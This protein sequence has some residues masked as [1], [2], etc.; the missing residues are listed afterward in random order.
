MFTL[1]Y[2]PLIAAL[3]SILVAQL[4]KVPIYFISHLALDPKL[5]FRTGG[6]PSSHSAAVAALTAGVGMKDGFS[7]SLFAIACLFGV[8]T[9]YDAAGLRRHA[10]THAAILNRMTRKLANLQGEEQALPWLRE[11]LGHRQAEVL[12]GAALGI[13]ISLLLHVVY[14]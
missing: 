14:P 11:T 8:I 6:M 13:A 4:V 3:I 12:A 5:A 7:S 10:G 9:M 2:L 1:P